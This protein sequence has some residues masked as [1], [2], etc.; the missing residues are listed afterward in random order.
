MIDLFD[1]N[2]PGFSNQ[3]R[4]KQVRGDSI[5]QL[6]WSFHKMRYQLLNKC[7]SNNKCHSG[8]SS[9]AKFALN[10]IL[11]SGTKI[12]W[13]IIHITFLTYNKLIDS[14]E[15]YRYRLIDNLLL[16]NKNLPSTTPIHNHAFISYINDHF[17]VKNLS[18]KYLS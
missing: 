12:F 9:L 7:Q 13:R 4:D 3:V 17:I 10:L 6:K 2:D 1:I 18:R 16:T 5:F 11:G 15:N 8:R 14:S